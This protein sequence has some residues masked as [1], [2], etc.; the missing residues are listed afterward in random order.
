M[1]KVDNKRFYWIKIKDTFLTSDKVDFLMSQKGGANYVVMYQALCLKAINTNGKLARMLGDIFVP[2]DPEKIQRDLKWF[3]ID[4]VRVGLELLMRLDLIRREADGALAINDF[5]NLIGSE[6]GAAERM[7][8][9]RI[10]SN[11]SSGT[12]QEQNGN[13]VPPSP[14]TPYPKILDIRDKRLEIRDK[15]KEDKQDKQDKQDKPLDVA[16]RLTD[17]LIEKEFIDEETDETDVLLINDLFQE[18][19]KKYDFKNILLSLRYTI[20]QAKGKIDKPYE[21]LWQSLHQNCEHFK[22]TENDY[23]I[24]EETSS[25]LK[26]TEDT[27]E[28]ILKVTLNQLQDVLDKKKIEIGKEKKS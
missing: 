17:F 12:G 8:L 15:T 2:F 3:D 18:L 13:I 6:T 26:K 28:D 19:L 24:K 20:N 14:H 25:F 1:A 22:N 4:T 5:E 10:K 21:Y 7:R 16:E 23:K 9:S 27:N 11:D